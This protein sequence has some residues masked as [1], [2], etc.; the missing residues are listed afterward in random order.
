MNERQKYL[1]MPFLNPICVAL[2]LDDREKLNL[3][4]SELA[5]LVGG[6]K[7]GPRLINQFGQ[8]I[9]SS[10]AKAAPVFVDCKYFD[11]PSTMVASV[12]SAFLA[13]ASAC[14]VHAL[15]GR[16]ALQAMAKLEAELNQ[17][18]PFRIFVVT[19]LTSWT[20]TSFP[21]VF[22]SKI[23][24]DNVSEL[25][26]FAEGCGLSSFVCSAHELKALSS[27]QRYLVTPGIRFE[28]DS[29]QDQAR[30]SH[31]TQAQSDGASLLVVGRPIIEDQ[32]P[33]QK[34]KEFLIAIQ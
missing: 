19:I 3:M 31:P 26:H 28:K 32:H 18:R 23:P 25:V 11:I 30:V 34:L 7:I 17:I 13:G 4:V 14:T 20:E 27:Q 22:R 29:T 6:F 5:S 21:P 12:R 10:V 33:L 24:A 2:D 1:S 15:S 9:I 8:E 16:E